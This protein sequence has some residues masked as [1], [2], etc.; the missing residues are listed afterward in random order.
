MESEYIK[1]AT[2]G[3]S[4]GTDGTIRIKVFPEFHDEA[5]KQDFIF[6]ETDNYHVPYRVIKWTKSDQYILFDDINDQFQADK[7]QG[8]KC[9][10]PLNIVS[11][12]IENESLP[13]VGF[14]L[15]SD[16]K[17]VGKIEHVEEM[18]DQLLATVII[19]EGE[20]LI[21]IHESLI[22][23]VNPEKQEL[24]MQLPEGLLDL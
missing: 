10:L 24:Y 6:I 15:Y 18:T 21:P 14:S 4:F 1:I 19:N 3:K 23:D 2:L 16:G 11:H 5:K 13:F 7:L 22:L 12:L 17:L 20:I 9:Y 8:K